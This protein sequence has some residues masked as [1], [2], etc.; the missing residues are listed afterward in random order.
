MVDE[1]Y[2]AQR[3]TRRQ[4]VMGAVT[5]LTGVACSSSNR[6]A[7]SGEAPYNALGERVGEVTSRSAIIH[8]RLTAQPVRNNRGYSFPLWTHNLTREQRLR[9]TIDSCASKVVLFSS[10]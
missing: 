1:S 8:T 7:S 6:P 5:L 10:R 3:V 4:A 9:D 2:K